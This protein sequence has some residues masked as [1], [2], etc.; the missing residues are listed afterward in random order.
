[1]GKRRIT[2]NFEALY[3]NQ[4]KSSA[5]GLKSRAEGTR[6]S[7]WEDRMMAIIPSEQHR[8]D[9]LIDL[10]HIYYYLLARLKT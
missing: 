5:D 8:E 3:S 7:E 4:N 10:L 6:K 2:W 1:M 9:R